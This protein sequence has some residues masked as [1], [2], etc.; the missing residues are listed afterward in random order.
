M[1]LLTTV[2]LAGAGC[3]GRQGPEVRAKDLDALAEETALAP[4][5]F[6]ATIAGVGR[7]MRVS[8]L[9][10]DAYRY[11]ATVSYGDRPLFEE[12]AVDDARYL[13][14]LDPRPFRAPLASV[15]AAAPLLAGKWV[16]DPAGAAPEFGAATSPQ[17][18]LLRLVDPGLETTLLAPSTVLAEVRFLDTLPSLLRAGRPPIEWNPDSANYIP[19]DDKFPPHSEDGKRFDALPQPFDPGATFA[20][21]P[22]V[23]SFFQTSAVWARERAISRIESLL[24][25]PTPGRPQYRDMFEQIARQPPLASVEGPAL[26]AATDGFRLAL[27]T[28]LRVEESR[29]YRTPPA[30]SAVRPPR[31]AVQVDLSAVLR[32]LQAARLGVATGALPGGVPTSI[33]GAIATALPRALPTGEA[34]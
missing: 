16:V 4:R 25:L 12:M 9:V 6:E 11:A 32:A 33:P 24:E 20:T 3:A 13:R 5:E 21:L 29:R 17:S 34:S 10:E 26:R 23:A 8:G 19:Q 14:L 7:S 15:P 18:A 30:G 28:G 27:A 31:G 2:L 22:A 1:V